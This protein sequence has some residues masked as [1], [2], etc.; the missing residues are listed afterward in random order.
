MAHCAA[1]EREK[2]VLFCRLQQHRLLSGRSGGMPAPAL[3]NQHRSAQSWQVRLPLQKLFDIPI[4]IG[5]A[6]GS[7]FF[8]RQ[9]QSHRLYILLT[10][11]AGKITY[12]ESDS[13]DKTHLERKNLRVNDTGH[14][15]RDRYV[16]PG[17]FLCFYKTLVI[18]RLRDS[19]KGEQ[20][21]C[22]LQGSDAVTFGIWARK[23]PVDATTNIPLMFGLKPLTKKGFSTQLSW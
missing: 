23:T 10:N 1:R 6:S 15:W 14:H 7:F 12:G 3:W 19:A 16:V 4:V 2:R 9:A 17:Y 18:A 5:F 21:L 22:E 11:R 20:I 8:K 13:G